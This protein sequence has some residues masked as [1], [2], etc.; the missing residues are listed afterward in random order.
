MYDIAIIGAGINGSVMA[1]EL[2]DDFKKIAVFDM[3]GIASGGSGAAGAFISPKFSKEGELKE[4]LEDSFLYAKEYYEKHFPHL[5][6]KAPLLHFAKDEKDNTTLKNYKKTATLKLLKIERN[7]LEMLTPQAQN[8]EKISIDGM[9]VNAQAICHAMCKG[10]DFIKQEVQSLVFDD[11]LWWINENYTAKKIILATG[12]YKNLIDE[13]YLNIRGVWG[14]RIDIKTSTKNQLSLHQFVSIS[15]SNEG[16]VSIGATHNVHYH[17]QTASE[18][19]NVKEGR[20]ELLEK[21]QRTLKLQDVEILKDY[22]GLRS[23]SADYM[24]LLGKLVLSSESMKLNRYKLESK[25]T[26]FHEYTYYN[27]L[28][29]INGSSGYGF[30]F[31]PTLAKMLKEHIV[32]NKEI[33]K[34]L[35]PAR[36]FARWAKRQ[37]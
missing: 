11:G 32:Q 1:Y 7:S 27:E 3:G 23:G 25:K 28:Y 34:R 19:Y 30:V 16:K 12:A 17:P 6:Q 35:S 21:A 24:P 20:A 9:I 8:M 18:P 22:T 37:L 10:A 4:L 13:P 2:R 31:A 36:Y 15:P 5:I 14:H 33:S 26:D 29:M